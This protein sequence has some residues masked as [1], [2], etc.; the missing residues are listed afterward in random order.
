MRIDPNRL[1][2]MPTFSTPIAQYGLPEDKHQELKDAVRES[3]RNCGGKSAW[4]PNLY[5]YYQKNGEHL[6]EDN[7]A[8][9][10]DY[11]STWL[12][13][14]YS[15]FCLDV[16]GWQSTQ[17]AYITDC[18]VNITKPGG[19]QVIHTHANAFVSGTYYLNMEGDCG[20][21]VFM[22]PAASPS[23]PYIGF[24]QSKRTQ[25]SNM[26]Q[27]GCA[28]E[29]ILLLWPGHISHYTERTEG[30]NSTRVSISMNFMPEVFT[31]GGYNYK[32]IRE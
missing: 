29:G 18:W 2:V 9:I 10:Y 3:L 26:S 13:E 6:L 15:D 30:E 20:D 17:N 23:R 19:E 11:F 1:G 5:H 27:N 4:H 21:I 24:Q 14:C 7:D 31:A 22:N 32:V 25:F 28:K 8:P 12:K 16:Q